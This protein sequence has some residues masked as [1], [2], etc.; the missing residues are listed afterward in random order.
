MYIVSDPADAREVFSNTKNLHF[1]PI[2]S[3]F[4]TNVFGLPKS[5]VPNI[6]ADVPGDGRLV[7]NI[8]P[9]FRHHLTMSKQLAPM[10]DA[11]IERLAT[12]VQSRLQ[13]TPL[14]V[15]M[16][17]WSRY[18]VYEASIAAIWG[19]AFLERY[20]DSFRA[21]QVFDEQVY[22]LFFEM[23][24]YFSKEARTARD[25]LIEMLRVYLEDEA[26]L[27]STMGVVSHR[28]EMLNN[29]GLSSH[30]S[31]RF[32]FMVFHALALFLGWNVTDGVQVYEWIPES[33]V[34]DAVFCSRTT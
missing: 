25:E 30:D 9:F 3:D 2:F 16:Y 19:M 22:T 23:G 15:P 20:P 29:A 8:H 10:T 27:E 33:R 21:V 26:N 31:A 12:T 17:E 1:S 5:A 14:E 28:Q 34:L 18:I 6:W 11:Y 13:D 32:Q 4:L 7:E 24:D